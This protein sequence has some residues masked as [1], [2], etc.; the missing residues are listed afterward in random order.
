MY[1]P[2]D[3]IAP[4]TPPRIPPRS[5]LIRLLIRRWDYRHPRI[6]IVVRLSCAIWNL[7]LGML[8]LAS[9]DSIG[10]LAWLGLVPL[11]GAVLLFL[12]VLHLQRAL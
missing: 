12:T 8:L 1:T 4:R 7:A 11:T 3:T 6:W 2:T 5:A 10:Q 9:G